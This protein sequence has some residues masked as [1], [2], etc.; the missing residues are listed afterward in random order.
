MQFFIQ[1]YHVYI[2][3]M[4]CGFG[5]GNI[6]LYHSTL[7][8]RSSVLKVTGSSKPTRL[9]SQGAARNKSPS[10]ARRKAS[11]AEINGGANNQ[12]WGIEPTNARKHGDLTNEIG[13]LAYKH[14][15]ACKNDDF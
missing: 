9:T 1:Y 2:G 3:D 12:I 8:H 15:L 13:D 11:G 6:W 7:D 5:P 10:L 14:D 4:S